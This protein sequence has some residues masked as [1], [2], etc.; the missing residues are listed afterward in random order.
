MG[1]ATASL[2]LRGLVLVTGFKRGMSVHNLNL[3][4]KII[5]T[6]VKLN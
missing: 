1:T 5:C 6:K 3:F 2:E 4:F